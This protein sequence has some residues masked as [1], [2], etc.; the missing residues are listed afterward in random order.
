MF[1]LWFEKKSCS[2]NVREDIKYLATK[3]AEQHSLKFILSCQNQSKALTSFLAL[4]SFFGKNFV[5]ITRMKIFV[6][7]SK[8]LNCSKNLQKQFKKSANNF[9]SKERTFKHHKFN[10]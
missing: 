2:K 1:Y 7:F 6:K 4:T 5:V 8:F 3:L 9:N 10:I